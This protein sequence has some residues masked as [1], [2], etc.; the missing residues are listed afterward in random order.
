MSAE[1]FEREDGR[2]AARALII[3]Q[4]ANGV[5]LWLDGDRLRFLC[6]GGALSE[7]TAAQL[8]ACRDDVVAVLHREACIWPA[9]PA[10]QGQRALWFAHELAGGDDAGYHLLTAVALADA[11]AEC[12][13][14]D[15]LAR[16]VERHEILRTRYAFQV[17]TLWQ[18]IEPTID[19]ALERIAAADDAIEAFGRRPFDL[20]TGPVFRAA[21]IEGRTAGRMQRVLVFCAHHIAMDFGSLQRL[22][23]ELAEDVGAAVQGGL[24]PPR[25]Y[26]EFVARQLAELSTDRTAEMMRGCRERLSPLPPLPELQRRTGFDSAGVEPASASASRYA[27]HAW[28]ASPEHAA[29]ISATAARLG[30]TAFGVCLGAFAIAMSRLGGQSRFGIHLAATLQRRE[31]GDALGNFANL[32]PMIADIDAAIAL[33]EQ[34][35]RIYAASQAALDDRDLP[36]P[37]LVEA[38]GLSGSSTRTPLTP[39]A[40]SWHRDPPSSTRTAIVAFGEVLACSRQIGPP[41]ALMLTGHDANGRF[42]FKIGYDAEDVAHAC[43]C[44]LE[45][46]LTTLFDLLACGGSTK[47]A[48]CAMVPASAATQPV[49]GAAMD[50]VTAGGVLAQIVATATA[51]PQADAV[52]VG[53]VSIGYGALMARAQGIADALRAHGIVPGD[54]VALHRRRDAHLVPSI[55]AILLAGATYVPIDRTYPFGRTEHILAISGARMVLVDTE[56]AF[57]LPDGCTAWDPSETEPVPLRT[58][59]TYDAEAIAYIIFTSGSTGRP[60]GVAIPHAGLAALAASLPQRLGVDERTA[61]LAISSITFDASIAELFMPLAVGARL[62]LADDGDARNPEALAALID[63]HRI[64]TMQATPTTW[65]S[66]MAAFP[67]ARW[68]LRAHSMGEAL[69]TALAREMSAHFVSV[70]NLYGPTEATVYV[71]AHAVDPV[72]HPAL[73]NVPVAQS[74]PGCTLWVL[75]EHRHPVASGVIGEVYLEGVHLAQGYWADP[76]ATARAFVRIPH[77]RGAQARFYRTGDLARA[78]GDGHMEIVG[79]SDFQA[80]LRGH[81]I[82][83]GEIESVLLED[84]EVE[85]AAVIVVLDPGAQDRASATLEA[86]VRASA[87]ENTDAM[88]ARLRSMLPAYMVP[89]RIHLV[90]ALP[91]ND[92][93]KID[94]VRLREL[95]IARRSAGPDVVREVGPTAQRLL[96]LLSEVLGREVRDAHASVFDLGADSLTAVRFAIAVREAFSIPL[97]MA[98]L[99]ARPALAELADWIDGTDGEVRGHKHDLALDHGYRPPAGTQRASEIRCVLLTGATGYLGSRVVRAL[100]ARPQL[101]LV[102]LVRAADDADADRRLWR[103]L[104]SHGIVLDA[105]ART[106]VVAIRATLGVDLFGLDADAY[107]RLAATVDAVVHCAALV[108]FSL[109]YASMRGNVTATLDMIRFCAARRP[110]PLHFVSTYSVLDPT[111]DRLPES[112]EVESHPF[113]DFGYARSKWVCEQ[114]LRQA[115]AAGLACRAYRPS[116]IVSADPA[117]PINP[118]DFYSLVLAGSIAAGVAPLDAGMD[119]FVPVAAVAER[120]AREAAAPID[121]ARAVHLCGERWTAWDL[122]LA[123]LADRGIA[124]EKVGYEIWLTRV[125]A[126]AAATD[127]LRPFLEMRGFLEGAADRLRRCFQERHP[128]LETRPPADIAMDVEFD[129][130]LIASHIARIAQAFSLPIATGDASASPMMETTR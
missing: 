107:H 117:E 31:D 4:A 35:L 44:A 82:E 123:R 127:S 84:P 115:A 13:L 113:L 64:D 6:V 30:I 111:A 47:L 19:I 81:R 114:L 48:D 10:S 28:D 65:K 22:L 89:T 14:A 85:D 112:L 29:A 18:R 38:L 73:I 97:P 46:A 80:K 36:F 90:D 118:G 25:Q 104:A 55:L 41:G 125:L 86:F 71:T 78:L 61:Y 40:F 76:D 94:R 52:V 16:A 95:A 87:V 68:R 32:V 83:P 116:R 15:A 43:A 70:S 126:V 119:N 121:D 77:L 98:E 72:R 12:A 69:P 24:R 124:L 8:R 23:T 93:G 105:E 99:F 26:R 57:G 1:S 33:D 51:R 59:P 53:D 96:R 110:K 67:G 108:N 109:P 66:L 49:L 39:I 129:N 45:I 88:R 2:E 106:R 122:I 34:I 100:L 21:V 58:L 20:A 37:I 62:V 75:D 42:D 54:R 130:D 79:R 101:R 7:A 50:P 9:I 120:I 11:V 92:N 91:V 17:G 3:D 74:L 102:C 56:P 60:K 27:V 128:V 5:R 103:S 63:R